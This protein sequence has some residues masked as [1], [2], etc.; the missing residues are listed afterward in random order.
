MRGGQPCQQQAQ[1]NQRPR[2]DLHLSLQFNGLGAVNARRISRSLPAGQTA[3]Q[4]ESLGRA[5]GLQPGGIVRGALSALAMKD[6]RWAI[7][8]CRR[9]RSRGQGR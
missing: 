1:K 9:K 4:N 8:A 3:F 6:D 5:A 2:G 7:F